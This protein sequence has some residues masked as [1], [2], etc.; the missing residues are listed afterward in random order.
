MKRISIAIILIAFFLISTSE[1]L[2]QIISSDKNS[3]AMLL[4]SLLL[5]IFL[6]CIT[7][8]ILFKEWFRN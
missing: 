4:L 1:I 2:P 7:I 8:R 6:S 3:L 5:F